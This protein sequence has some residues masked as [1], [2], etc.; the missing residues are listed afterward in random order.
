MLAHDQNSQDKFLA[1]YEKVEAWA[2]ARNLHMGATFEAQC[3]KLWEE[4]GE[5]MQGFNKGITDQVVDGIGDMAVVAIVMNTICKYAGDENL[6]YED[7]SIFTHDWAIVDGKMEA[8]LAIPEIILS[9]NEEGEYYNYPWIIEALDI[10]AVANGLDLVEC[11]QSAYD[12]IKDR[13]GQMVNGV[14]IKEEDSASICI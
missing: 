5:L 3:G 1:L 11:L 12:T 9:L 2:I 14:F 10:A 7:P 6:T 4:Y 13:K 8:I